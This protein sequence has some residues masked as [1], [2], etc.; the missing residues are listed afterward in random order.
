MNQKII[1]PLPFI[2]NNKYVNIVQTY[3][4]NHC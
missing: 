1:I 3:Q 2:L 4:D